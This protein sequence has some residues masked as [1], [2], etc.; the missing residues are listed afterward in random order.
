MPV[1]VVALAEVVAWA[2][3]VESSPTG[4]LS[5]VGGGWGGSGSSL[6]VVPQLEVETPGRYPTPGD[7]CLQENKH[8]I[9]SHLNHLHSYLK[10]IKSYLCTLF[11]LKVQ[12]SE[13]KWFENAKS[14][15]V[16]FVSERCSLKS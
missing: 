16:T 7:P 2:E 12:I 6:I 4:V 15:F 10:L 14:V 8:H 1:V 11:A 5:S 13:L 9:E 3:V